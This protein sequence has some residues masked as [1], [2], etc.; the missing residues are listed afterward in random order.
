ML[1]LTND[2]DID[3]VSNTYDHEEEHGY[4]DDENELYAF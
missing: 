1:E 2:V 3:Y 4:R